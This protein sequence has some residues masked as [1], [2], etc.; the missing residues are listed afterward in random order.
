MTTASRPSPSRFVPSRLVPWAAA[1]GLLVA[2]PVAG[3]QKLPDKD[4]R[5]GE[6]CLRVA[7]PGLGFS[8]EAAAAA[9][10]RL[11][12]APA[13]G[14]ALADLAAAVEAA[15]GHALA[16]ETTAENLRVRRTA[17]DRFA[18]VAHVDGD[19]YFL[20]AGFTPRGLVQVIDP[21][22]SYD[23]PPETLA[24]RWDGKALLL[25]RDPLT[26]EGDLPGPFPWRIALLIAAVLCGL[27]GAWAWRTRRSRG[28]S[29]AGPRTAGLAAGAVLLLGAAGCDEPAREESAAVAGPPRAVF[30]AVRRDA[31]TARPTRA[32]LGAG[33][34]GVQRKVR[35]LLVA[36]GPLEVTEPPALTA[37]AL[38]AAD[39]AAADGA[40]GNPLA[41][42][43]AEVVRLSPDR[44]AVDLT[45]PLPAAA[46][47]HAAILRVGVTV[48]TDDGPEA[49]TLA[50][51]VSALTYAA[52]AETAA[53]PTGGT[54]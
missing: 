50:V 24:A 9:V 22:I 10:D 43:T 27:A 25:S 8:D 36:D 31:G 2:A 37:A 45:G 54:R 41:G 23:L 18:C 53:E 19:H 28:A 32:F 48:T 14:H 38:T 34:A 20:I 51:P 15:G 17:G 35:I 1:L 29:P 52:T 21:P 4:R 49:R 3:A 42:V 40:A 44:A 46:G 26:A 7:L 6:Y 16:V 11:G 30:E 5:C 12:A 39:G 47:P 33:P 13:G